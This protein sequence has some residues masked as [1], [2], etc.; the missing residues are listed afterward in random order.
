MSTPTAKVKSAVSDP[1]EVFQQMILQ[2]MHLLQQS[3]A[4][5]FKRVFDQ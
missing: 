3:Q 5:L 4:K 2:Q 1:N